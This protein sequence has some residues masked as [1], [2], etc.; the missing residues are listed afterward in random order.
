VLHLVGKQVKFSM[1]RITA[2]LFVFATILF[3]VIGQILIKWQAMQSGSFPADWH[4]RMIFFFHLV[5][6]RWIILG[7]LSAVVAAFSWIIAMTRLPLSV[8]YPIVA[9][10]YPLV[11]I[12]GWLLFDETLSYWRIFGIILIILG[13]AVIGVNS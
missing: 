5:L 1:T 2:F 9:L 10:T 4:G 3:T 8:A 7:L 12:L 11:F 13:V 6:N